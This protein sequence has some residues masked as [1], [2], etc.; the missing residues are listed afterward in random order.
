MKKAKLLTLFLCCLI[1]RQLY[2]QAIDELGVKKGVKI[3][4]SVS[5]NSVAYM[6]HG[7]DSRRDP[8]N[9]FLQ[10]NLNINLFGYNMPFSFSYS[11]QGRNFAQPFNR[12]QFAPSYKWARGYFGNTSMTFSNYT[13]AGHMFNGAGV[14]L[15]PGKWRVA[16]MYGTLLKAVPFDV[17]NKESYNSAAFER[18]GWGW[19][20]GYEDKGNSYS[21]SFFKAKDDANSI[22]FVPADAT[23]TPRENTAVAVSVRQSF[24]KRLFTDVEY[25]VSVLNRDVRAVKSAEDSLQ[26]QFNLV[27]QF[28]S[29]SA[30]TVYFDALQAGL[31]YTG[32]FYSIQMRFER[33]APGYT[34]LGA[35]NLVNDMRNITIAP[36]VQLFNNR[37]QISA[38]AGIQDNNL[39][40][41][42]TTTT[43]R[44][45]G[46]GNISVI[47][48]Q[49]WM[50][51]GSYSNFTTFTRVRP[52]YDPYFS[53]PL[54]SLN[55][56]QVNTS[57]NGVVAYQFG[58]KNIRHGI[59][60]TLNY[61]L[62]GDAQ[63]SQQG[64]EPQKSNFYTAN[65]G[66]TFNQ[67]QKDLS[68]TAGGNYYVQ[69]MPGARTWFTGPSLSA[70]KTLL[71]KKL[72]LNATSAYNITRST[73]NNVTTRNGVWNN[74]LQASFTPQAQSNPTPNGSGI[75]NNKKVT[76]RHSLNAAVNYLHQQAVVPRPQFSELTVTMG[77]NFS[78]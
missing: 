69:D 77:Y 13:L 57:Y 2:A 44:W 34:T 45:V 42:K 1:S 10:G 63:P 28:L 8:F 62:A 30:S 36:S 27:K 41:T 9:W 17:N 72:R 52:V 26:G 23:L 37:V 70:A 49:H 78:F 5:A 31:G 56:Y 64:T 18:K 60:L 76:G 16:G 14:E 46:S 29:P 71:K 24:F 48:N 11:N 33:V 53:N 61:Q 59:M 32:N 35:Y 38:N 3:N 74:A 12:F 68:L 66:Y 50:V 21:I 22:P 39:D 15:S 58:D 73:V 51:N 20:A 7:I 47:P 65:A 6:A 55:F 4:G 25:S 40:N 43:R 19:K 75:T 67:L 54:D